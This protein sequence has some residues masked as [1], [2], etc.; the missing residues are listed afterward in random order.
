MENATVTLRFETKS[1]AETF[2]KLWA[3]FA[4]KGNIVGSGLENVD[5]KV[6]D[7][8]PIQLEWIKEYIS[9]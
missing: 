1:S 2:A 7:V 9:K 5:V 4:K 6:Y 3:R 8:T